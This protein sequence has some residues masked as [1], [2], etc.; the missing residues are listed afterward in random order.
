MP[1]IQI[2][3]ERNARAEDVAFIEE[4]VDTFNMRMTGD[5]EW[6]PVHVF[7]RDETGAL[8]GGLTATLWGKWMHIQYLWVD[9]P[10][11]K[12]GYGAQLMQM[13]EDEARQFG[14]L[15]AHVETFSFQARPFYERLG[16]Q[17][18]AEMADY[19]PGHS[20]YLLRKSLVDPHEMK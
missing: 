13:A 11:R 3:V 14:C 8:R 4:A 20:M 1:V 5:H 12:Y 16:Y 19:P 18:V 10:L 17:V 2:A 15:N 9:E 7:I 6:K